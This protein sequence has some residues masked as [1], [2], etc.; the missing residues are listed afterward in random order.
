IRLKWS[1]TSP[2]PPHAVFSVTRQGLP[3]N[4]RSVFLASVRYAMKY[5][6]SKDCPKR[7]RPVRYRCILSKS[8]VIGICLCI[9]VTILIS[10]GILL[11]LLFTSHFFGKN[12]DHRYLIPGAAASTPSIGTSAKYVFKTA[13]LKHYTNILDL[14]EPNSYVDRKLKVKLKP[15]PKT[16]T[17]TTSTT[18]TT[19]TAVY[20]DLNADI[21]STESI[22]GTT[23]AAY[24]SYYTTTKKK[25]VDYKHRFSQS[26]HPLHSDYLIPGSI[27]CRFKCWPYS[28]P[29]FQSSCR[30]SV[31][32][33]N[34]KQYSTNTCLPIFKRCKV[35]KNTDHAVAFWQQQIQTSFGCYT[36]DKYQKHGI[37]VICSMNELV[38]D[39]PIRVKI[40]VTETAIEH[41]ITLVLASYHAGHWVIGLEHG[42]Q[43]H[44]VIL[45]STLNY[46][47]SVVSVNGIDI[48]DDDDVVCK[49]RSS[50]GYGDDR[51]T[52]RTIRLLKTIYTR[53][54]PISSFS[55]AWVANAWALVIS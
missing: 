38:D 52:G 6:V 53:V 19:T 34:S 48:T 26:T 8:A 30:Y 45:L 44:S 36:G 15:K 20:G 29:K 10:A 32:Q 35:R 1:K 7:S 39:Q 4:I 23:S 22:T 33:C 18:T 46:K 42:I 5:P 21:T 28:D 17:T 3:R 49:Y 40:T 54:G 13:A 43:L 24:N 41:P 12:S 31:C 16:T 2:P 27:P 51:F 50:I 11:L 47:A 25:L 37:H 55:G 9:M 14:L